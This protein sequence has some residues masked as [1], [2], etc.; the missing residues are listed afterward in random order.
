MKYII[1][2][3]KLSGK[4]TL[5][6]TI[7]QS[8]PGST[9]INYRG[10]T[11]SSPTPYKLNSAIVR[12]ML[13]LAAFLRLHKTEPFIIIRAH[14]YP[15]A[16]AAA[17]GQKV[18]ASFLTLDKRFYAPDIMLIL[19]TLDEQHYRGRLLKRLQFE[20]AEKEWDRH[21]YNVESLQTSYLR[22]FEASCL[23]KMRFDSGT[24]STAA[25]LKALSIP[26]H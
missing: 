26:S 1:E 24:Y 4:T 22:H 10:Y 12:R 17:T 2:G 6:D 25:I 23:P 19:L 13:H 20:R 7:L 15:F 8:S 11:S 3:V 5:A 9:V 14:L 16:I 21:W 18:A